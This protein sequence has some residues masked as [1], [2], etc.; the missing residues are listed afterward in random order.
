MVYPNPPP[1]W[2]CSL[3]PEP[4]LDFA[5]AFLAGPPPVLDFCA[6]WLMQARVE[7][8]E[9]LVAQL[10]LEVLELCAVLGVEPATQPAS[11]SPNGEASPFALAC[12]LLLLPGPRPV[13]LAWRRLLQFQ[14]APRRRPRLLSTPCRAPAGPASAARP[15][16]IPPL[17]RTHRDTVCRNIN[18]WLR[19]CLAG[20][21]RGLRKR[22]ASA[23]LS[24][25]GFF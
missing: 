23:G 14:P 22:S 20:D 15:E 4:A 5:L 16:G 6:S 24:V 3:H 8:L 13:D 11:G 2:I 1:V 21:H 19:R 10:Q 12:P 9:R 25:L 17:P 7:E 18:A